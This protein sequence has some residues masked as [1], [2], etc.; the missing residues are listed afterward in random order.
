MLTS[1]VSTTI[2]LLT[3]ILVRLSGRQFLFFLVTY[4]ASRA[5]RL[6]R[7]N[8]V[9]DDTVSRRHRI[10]TAF[11]RLV[12]RSSSW[13]SSG[14]ECAVGLYLDLLWIYYAPSRLTLVGSRDLGVWSAA[15]MRLLAAI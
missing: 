8:G 9:P 2:V 4:Y 3:S 12:L 6:E 15:H 13:R 7:P 11:K 14:P 1:T 10:Q 5:G